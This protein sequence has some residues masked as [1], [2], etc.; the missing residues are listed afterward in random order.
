ML[1]QLKQFFTTPTADQ[2]AQREYDDARRELL[3]SQ[4][5]AEYHQSMIEYHIKRLLRLKEIINASTQD[6]Q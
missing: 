3:I 6:D 4:S 2:L 5:A 1:N